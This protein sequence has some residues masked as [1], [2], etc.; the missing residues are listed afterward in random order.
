MFVQDFIEIP[1]PIETVLDRV[2]TARWLHGQAVPGRVAVGTP[3]RRDTAV[4]V[5]FTFDVDDAG[6]T[7]TLNGD[8]E[9]RPLPDGG[10]HVSVSASYPRPSS[11]ALDYDVTRQIAVAVRGMLRALH[12]ALVSGGTLV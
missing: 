12:A 4:L 10:T 2:T 6:V 7:A 9:L 1:R 11:L 5:P 8:L 3:R